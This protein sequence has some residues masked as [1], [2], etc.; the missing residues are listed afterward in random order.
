MFLFALTRTSLNVA[1]FLDAGL[2]TQEDKATVWG[3][4]LTIITDTRTGRATKTGRGWQ[5]FSRWHRRQAP[6]LPRFLPT[7]R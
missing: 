4:H 1:S 6:F 2:F 5:I 7:A 3:L